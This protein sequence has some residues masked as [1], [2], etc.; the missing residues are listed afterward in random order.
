MAG[1]EPTDVAPE[2]RLQSPTAWLYEPPNCTC[3][4]TRV[5]THS[6]IRMASS[7]FALSFV[8]NWAVIFGKRM[9]DHHTSTSGVPV[10]S[11]AKL[12]G[13]LACVTTGRAEQCDAVG[14]CAGAALSFA[15]R[16]KATVATVNADFPTVVAH[17][18]KVWP[19]ADLMVFTV[20]P[21]RLR[22]AF[23]ATVGAGWQTYLSYTAS[24]GT[25]AGSRHMDTAAPVVDMTTAALVP[26]SKAHL[27]H[28]NQ[29]TAR[30][31]VQ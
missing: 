24:Q 4:L 17:D 27:A 19:L 3:T 21:M 15:E 2:V 12:V 23:V 10:S 9:V 28:T 30:A 1:N 22:V 25:A 6:P 29:R 7:W 5:Y 18:L 20:V 16:A 14:A 11:P 8:G 31:G 13:D 26:S